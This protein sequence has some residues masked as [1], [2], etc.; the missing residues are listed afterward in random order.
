MVG[1]LGRYS[2]LDIATKLRSILAGSGHEDLPDRTTR[3]VRRLRRLTE[4][5]V[6]D[7]VQRY[8]DG[9]PIHILARDFGLHRTTISAHLK[10]R[11]VWKPPRH[12][13]KKESAEIADRYQQGWSIARAAEYFGVSQSVIARVLNDAGVPTRP[14]G[15]N[16]WSR[17]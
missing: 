12:L 2:K 3:S 4:A 13:T 17:C 6:S 1:L 9:C 16:Q 5:E 14:V 10:T 8:Q 7:L 11:G 15:T